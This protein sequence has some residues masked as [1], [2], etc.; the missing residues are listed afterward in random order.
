MKVVNRL[1]TKHV[2]TG[3]DVK[4]AE[5]IAIAAFGFLAS[6]PEYFSR[7]A[8]ITGIDIADVAEIA[9]S[10]EFLS[11]VLTY[12]LSDESLL[13]SFCQNNDLLP[14]TVNTA[15]QVMGSEHAIS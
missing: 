14:E 6:E 2:K 9:G 5:N 3:I 10:T 12:M 13:L 15:Y 4:N 11:A 1:K 8:T 7:F